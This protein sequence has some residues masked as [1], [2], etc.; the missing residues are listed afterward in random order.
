MS[1]DNDAANH[2][3]RVLR[4]RRGD[5]LILFNGDGLDYL[6]TIVSA[7]RDD[8]RVR[9]TSQES[10]ENE[11]PLD[12]SILQGI[13]RTQRMDWLIQKATELGVTKILPIGC[14]RSVVRLDAKRS[15]K[16]RTHWQNV[17]ASACEQCGRARLP[18][19]GEPVDLATALSSV[20]TQMGAR[21]VLEPRG[22]RSIQLAISGQQQ[23]AL[24][25]GPEGGLTNEEARLAADAGFEG[26]RLGPR[27]LRAE[28]APIAALSII[29]YLAG[30]L[31]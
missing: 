17:A 16:K 18:E 15:G 12:V 19:I 30:D 25:I 29:Q 26:I 23:V 11:S 22:R 6:V 10:P 20:N 3:H 9:V 2:V 14:A 5:S 8:V 21:L 4:R 24:L 31:S 28:T 13:C 1:L 27:I 7:T